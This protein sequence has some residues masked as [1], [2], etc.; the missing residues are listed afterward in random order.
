MISSSDYR[1]AMKAYH[2]GVRAVFTNPWENRKTTFIEDAIL[3]LQTFTSYIKGFFHEQIDAGIRD[4]QVGWLKDRILAL[5]NIQSPPEVSF[6]LLQSVAKFFE[7]AITFVV[8]P[9]ELVGEKAIGVYSEKDKGASL[10]AQD[11]IVRDISLP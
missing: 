10:A 6:A 5:R 4:N 3:F 7:R 2:D 9:T 8:R 11:S 1:G